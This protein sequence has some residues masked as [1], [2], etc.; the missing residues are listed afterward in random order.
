MRDPSGRRQAKVQAAVVAGPDL[1]L[2]EYAH[3]VESRA[4]GDS[5]ACIPVEMFTRED[6][7]SRMPHGSIRRKPPQ[8]SAAHA[9]GD[10][11]SAAGDVS[12]LAEQHAT[13][14]DVAVSQ[15]GGS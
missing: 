5:E 14:M 3:A 12:E 10:E 7:T 6:A 1:P 8:G 2:A 15:A 9:R 4:D 13:S 11:R